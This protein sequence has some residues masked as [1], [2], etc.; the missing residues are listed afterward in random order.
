MEEKILLG[1]GGGGKL[2]NDLIRDMIVSSLGKDSIQLDDSAAVK[3]S[4]E[5]VVF[6]TDTFT[7]SPIFFPG[8]NI[9]SLAVHGTVNDLSVMGA[10]PLYLSCGLIIEEGFEI[11][12]L[13]IILDTM[14]SAAD[15][16]GIKIVTGDT[17]VVEKGK[18]DRIFINTA[19][20]GQLE[21]GLQRREI[22]VGDKL[23]VN[24]TIGDHGMAILSQRN[25]LS[26]T[27]DLKSDS[28][29]LN[30][31]IISVC[32]KYPG[33]IKF[34][35][36]AT[37]GGLASVLNEIVQDKAFSVKVVEPS[38]PIREE[39]RGVCDILGLDPLYSANEGKVTM[40]V[41]PQ[42]AEEILEVI[43]QDK[44]GREAA[45]IGEITDEFP[46]KVYVETKV[47]GKRL[48]PLLVDDQLPR[49]C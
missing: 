6:T 30:H 19:G 5:D 42:K 49:I 9:G 21:F 15:E 3:I 27:S 25:E 39:V 13:K 17:K 20:I 40:V 48:L 33:Q 10:R 43:K 22:E 45:I 23:I 26:F 1:H 8:G 11:K 16:A 37:R 14:K 41:K 4:E 34:M 35:R 46:G 44:Y 28:V 24:G 18:A 12:N 31:L 2:M 36:D 29:P 47:K 38:V 7:V 32:E